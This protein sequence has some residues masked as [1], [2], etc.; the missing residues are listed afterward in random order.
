MNFAKSDHQRE[1]AE[2]ILAFAGDLPAPQGSEFNRDAW[3]RLGEHG[4][5]GL[6]VPS[7]RGGLELDCL[8]TALCLEALGQACP[9]F[10]L[11]FSA[12]A[13]LF[14]GV[15]PIVEHAHPDVSAELVPGLV[16]GERIAANAITEAQAGSDV[17]ALTTRVRRDGD[18]YVLDGAK[19]YVTN[20]PVADVFVVYATQDPA[21]GFLGVY[22]F[23]V[24][25]DTPGL[26]VG[27][28][29]ET[30]GLTTSPISSLY[31]D[32][33]R[34]SE[35]YLLGGPGRGA[36]VFNQSMLWERSCL[37]AGYLGS[38]QRQLDQVVTYAKHRRQGKKPIGKHQ[39]VAHRIADMKLRLEASR[40]LLYHACWRRDHGDTSVLEAALAKLAI[41]EGAIQSALDA[42]QVHGGM[43][44]ATETGVERALRDAVPSTVFS[45][46]SEVQRTLVARELGL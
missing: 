7:A 4:V 18:H 27:E 30:M 33:C 3:R 10:G 46:T 1:L 32:G 5:L 25:R 34:V 20:G 38:M 22:A 2:N 35:R 40:W 13:H 29:F 23:A 24:H 31:L 6:C 16:S 39:A 37:F 15:M 43:G 14:A 9:D 28:R 19:S 8:T 26:I 44:F 12:S 45:G 36:A 21:H 17:F 42:L 41:S 11:V